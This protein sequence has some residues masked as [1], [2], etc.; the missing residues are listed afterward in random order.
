MIL[1]ILIIALLAAPIGLA[2]IIIF[3]GIIKLAKDKITNTTSVVSKRLITTGIIIVVTEIICVGSL[4]I[5]YKYKVELRYRNIPN[6]IEFNGTVESFEID[7]NTVVLV[8]YLNHF[9]YDKFESTK[10]NAVV[11]KET[12]KPIYVSVVTPYKIYKAYDTSMYCCEDELDEIWNYYKDTYS[13]KWDYIYPYQKV[14]KSIDNVDMDMLLEIWRYKEDLDFSENY[15][16]DKDLTCRKISAYSRDELSQLYIE[17][18]YDSDDNYY[19]INSGTG[20]YGSTMPKEYIEFI[21]SL[22]IN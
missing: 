15:T 3:I 5:S 22:N 6:K 8:D 4:L 16:I 2:A 20:N 10:Y 1:G 12:S 13:V 19:F 17:Y 9:I 7:E 18:G 14:D 21:K 11:G